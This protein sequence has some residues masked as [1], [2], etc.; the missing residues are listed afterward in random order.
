MDCISDNDLAELLEDR[1][2][3]PRRT[4]VL[5]ELARCTD[6]RELARQWALASIDG[7]RGAPAVAAA[8]AQLGPYRLDAL[9]G[10]GAM[11]LVF[12][13]HDPT[14]AR[15]VAV[16][17]VRAGDA[18]ERARALAEGRL[19]AT[20]RHPAV[21]G[22]HAAGTGDGVAYLA[23]ELVDGDSLDRVL[24]AGPLPWR[25]AARWFGGVALGLA[26]AHAAGVIH[27][28]VKPANLLVDGAT[29]RLADFGL[30]ST[31][32]GAPAGT[33]AQSPRP[34]G[35]RPVTLSNS[36]THSEY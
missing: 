7:G 23:M 14:L 13:G 35:R 28:D 27:R 2:P 17:V 21:V 11:G 16:K 20:V 12:R 4:A 24:A 33:P 29:L 8:G 26:A 18:A 22:V 6:C 10:A 25:Q 3:A 36:A 32:G 1:L 19:L 30:A 15:D 31:D 5:A 9:I 34:A